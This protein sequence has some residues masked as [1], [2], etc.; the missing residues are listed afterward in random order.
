MGLEAPLLRPHPC[1][2]ISR[3][4]VFSASRTIE[5]ELPKVPHPSF[6]GKSS[7]KLIPLR[8]RGGLF[9]LLG[10]LLPR[11]PRTIYRQRS[12]PIC[13]AGPKLTPPLTHSPPGG[14][15]PPVKKMRK[16]IWESRPAQSRDR[17]GSEL[18]KSFVDDV[19]L[20]QA[21]LADRE[22]PNWWQNFFPRL[23]PSCTG[24]VASFQRQTMG[25]LNGP[26]SPPQGARSPPSPIGFN[27][28]VPSYP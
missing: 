1:P 17:P 24:C 18:R 14:S 23:L 28:P 19:W 11:A 8:S 10:L 3:H 7:A 9:L 13:P 20:G 21:S 2:R 4:F 5:K 15:K 27:D 25:R 6:I 22:I 12:R 26:A 16:P